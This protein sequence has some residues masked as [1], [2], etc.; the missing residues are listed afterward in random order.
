MLICFAACTSI[1]CPL[2]NV[3]YSRFTF[4]GTTDGKTSAVS[5][6]D[7]LT[8]TAV[9][10]DSVLVNK[11]YGASSLS[12]PVSYYNQT[13]VLLF[14]YA[15]TAGQA[16]DTLWIDKTNYEHFESPDCPTA[17]FHN[18]QGIR[19]TR[20]FIDSIVVENPVIDYNENNNFKIYFRG[21]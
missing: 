18:I 5:L 15:S 13:D 21:N 16:H 8:V 11:D 17:M 19:H 7:T 9:G 6:E 20:N 4:Y 12:L 10:T 2:N 1:D 3:V 14:L